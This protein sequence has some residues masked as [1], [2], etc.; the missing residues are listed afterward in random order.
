MQNHDLSICEKPLF[1]KAQDLLQ[2]FFK[3]SF[4]SSLF[5]L[6]QSYIF[7]TYYWRSAILK[8]LRDKR[9]TDLCYEILDVHLTSFCY[10]L[11]SFK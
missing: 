7:V 6:A 1:E 3:I 9:F 11:L 4:S 10:I 5:K 2:Y 8:L